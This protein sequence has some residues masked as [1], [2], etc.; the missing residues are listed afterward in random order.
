MLV[1]ITSLRNIVSE[2][3]DTGLLEN[4]PTF[5]MSQDLLETLFGRLRSLNG[6]NDNP[7][8]QQFSSAL[9]KLLIHNEIVSS[10]LSNCSDQL[11]ILTVSSLKQKENAI[12]ES[13]DQ[14][15]E[16]EG[17]TDFMNDR[18]CAN[19]YLLNVFKDSTVVRMAIEIE[20]KIKMVARFDCENC[21]NVLNDNPGMQSDFHKY[22]PCLSIILIGKVVFKFV[23]IFKN[24]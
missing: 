13:N 16:A 20:T 11:K 12:C 9:R 14:T 15:D 2:Y 18:F 7:S 24:K 6:N 4:I 1:N 22:M 8:V 3:L 5:R 21:M 17:N 23:D 10:D 19:D